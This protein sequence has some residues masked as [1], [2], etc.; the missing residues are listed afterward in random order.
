MKWDCCFVGDEQ[1][2]PSVCQARN[3]GVCGA[4]TCVVS[5]MFGIAQ[6]C[7]CFDPLVESCEHAEQLHI[8]QLARWNISCS[9]RVLSLG[10]A[11]HIYYQNVRY[12][13]WRLNRLRSVAYLNII[14]RNSNENRQNCIKFLNM[15]Q[16]VIFLFSW[17]AKCAVVCFGISWS[18][19]FERNVVFCRS[20]ACV[21]LQLAIAWPHAC[22]R[23]YLISCIHQT[24]TRAVITPFGP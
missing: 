15:K 3:S 23:C 9:T 19:Q 17:S 20:L 6:T 10:C 8:R 14:Q 21:C 13:G 22:W 1:R 18:Q 12:C 11:Y 24:D 16:P 2:T 7:P 5:E 4:L